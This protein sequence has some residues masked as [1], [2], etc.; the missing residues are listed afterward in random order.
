MAQ[1]RRTRA[2]LSPSRCQPTQK[3]SDNLACGDVPLRQAAYPWLRP[4][5]A[6][7]EASL[8]SSH[9]PHALVR[10][11]HL[12]LHWSGLTVVT[13]MQFAHALTRTNGTPLARSTGLRGFAVAG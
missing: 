2:E 10:S 7:R 11:W 12:P 3:P 4:P 8:S 6:E 9:G 5:C 1:T 13:F